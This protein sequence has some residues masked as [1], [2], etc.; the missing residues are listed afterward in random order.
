MTGLRGGAWQLIAANK[1]NAAPEGELTARHVKK[2]AGMSKDTTFNVRVQPA[3]D[4]IDFAVSDTFRD[5]F[6]SKGLTYPSGRFHRSQRSAVQDR[7]VEVLRRELGRWQARV[8]DLET[9]LRKLRE[10]VDRLRTGGADRQ[11][12]E[13]GYRGVALD[14]IA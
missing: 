6:A 11:P 12:E 8:I 1:N 4:A 3:D 2:G 13:A 10:E 9:I 14:A 5:F 7:Q